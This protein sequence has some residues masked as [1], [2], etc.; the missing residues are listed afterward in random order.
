M[1]ENSTSIINSIGNSTFIQEMETGLSNATGL[2]PTWADL[3][4]AIFIVILSYLLAKA[5]KYF[6]KDVAPHLVSKT[7]T[8]LDDEILKAINGPLQVFIMAVGVYIAFATLNDLPGVLSDNLVALLTIALVYIAAYLVSNLATA[9]INWYKNDVAPKT[10]SELDDAL[11]PFLAKAVWML[12]FIVATLMVLALFDVNITPLIATLGVGGIAVALAAQEFLSNVFGAFAVLS[13]RPY[14]IGDRIQLADGMVGDVV[15]IGIR[16]TRIKTLDSRLII[17]P[18]ADISKSNIINYSLPD[19]KVRFD[20]KV[21]IA[22][23]SDVEKASSIL[24]DIAAHTEGV[25]KDPAPKVYIKDLGDFSI[26]LLMHVWVKDYKLSWEV[27]D[28][29]YRETLKRFAAENVEIPFPVTTVLLKMQQPGV[30]VEA[31]N[32]PAAKR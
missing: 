19:A 15:E 21:G 18:N 10:N 12:V 23:G 7:E 25:L 9:V 28:R 17:V 13:D 24:L 27:P 3:I 14:K 30:T 8:T 20:I 4:I 29:I 16:S 32:P 22:Y 11:M 1:A 2:S 26:N 6:I 5:V 31:L